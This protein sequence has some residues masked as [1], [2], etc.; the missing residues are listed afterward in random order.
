MFMFLLVI[1]RKTKNRETK[2]RNAFAS[3][4]KHAQMMETGVT[5]LRISQAYFS[6]LNPAI[7]PF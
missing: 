4:S 7:P 6:E 2:T 5:A 3:Q 1:P